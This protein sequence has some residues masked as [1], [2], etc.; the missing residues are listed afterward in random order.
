MLED[1]RLMFNSGLEHAQGSPVILAAMQ[2]KTQ[3]VQGTTEA[4]QVC[5]AVRMFVD[6][7]LKHSLGL[8]QQRQ[9]AFVLTGVAPQVSDPGP[10]RG[11][12]VAAFRVVRLFALQALADRSEE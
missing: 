11:K 8:V 10:A 3:V 2:H 1:W 4:R 12:I 7:I 5:E 6:Q 9:A